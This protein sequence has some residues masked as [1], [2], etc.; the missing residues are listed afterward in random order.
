MLNHAVL[1]AV[2]LAVPTITLIRTYG[3]NRDF[4]PFGFTIFAAQEPP[5]GWMVN[6]GGL[7]HGE[8]GWLLSILIA[9]HIVMAGAHESIWRDG[10]LARMRGRRRAAN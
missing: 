10:T 4:A 5:I 9:G 1:Y 3:S 7:L 6:P 2:M 8:P